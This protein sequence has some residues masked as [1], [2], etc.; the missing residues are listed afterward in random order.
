MAIAYLNEGAIS[1]AA[2]NWSDATGFANA[3]TLVISSG[4]QTITTS[5]DQSTLTAGI[6]T[7]DILP[8]FTGR[9]G[10]SGY[11]SLKVDADESTTNRIIYNAGGGSAYFQASGDNSIIS[12]FWM[13][14]LG[15]AYLTGGTFSNVV[16]GQGSL[17]VDSTTVLTDP[18][19]DGGAAVVQAGTAATSLTVRGGSHV[20]KRGATTINV[21]GRGRLNIDC[22]GTA[23]TTLNILSSEAEVVLSSS[24]T[25]TTVNN[26]GRLLADKITRAITISTYNSGPA[27]FLADS[28]SYLTRSAIGRLGAKNI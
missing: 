17:S 20:W 12:N 8:G 21:Y 28:P 3:A 23:I 13:S 18:I 27:G 2:A 1:L 11:G 22:A 25:I 16:L 19:F 9:I 26:W 14:S 5:L 24:G 4:S 6:D 15:S 10:G 7:L